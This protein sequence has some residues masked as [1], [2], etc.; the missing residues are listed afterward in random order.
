LRRRKEGQEGGNEPPLFKNRNFDPETRT[1]RK[2]GQNSDLAPQDTVEKDVDGL[3]QRILQDD[4]ERRTKDLDIHNI[5]PKRV[6]WDLKRDLN[7]KLAKLDRKTQ[8]SIHTLIR[9]R[10]AAQKGESDDLLGVINAQEKAEN[11]AEPQSDDE[12]D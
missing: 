5:A 4:E 1:L 11:V 2:A 3:S 9:R 12:E 7:K 10:L 8:E 6:N